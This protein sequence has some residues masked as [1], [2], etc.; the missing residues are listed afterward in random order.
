[1]GSTGFEVTGIR[2]QR[3]S[4]D[5]DDPESDSVLL[6]QQVVR[7]V[8]GINEHP[9]R[10]RWT[11]DTA[12]PAGPRGERWGDT[13]FA[14]SLAAARERSDQPVSV[15][16]RAARHRASREHDDVVRELRG[17]DLVEP[18][19]TALNLQWIISH[20]DLVSMAELM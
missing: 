14:R 2:T 20:P 9:P 7:A 19:P 1:W 3:V 15:D 13:H 12:A 18:H 17:L 10:L 11:I 8:H 4:A 5:P 16:S 6:Q